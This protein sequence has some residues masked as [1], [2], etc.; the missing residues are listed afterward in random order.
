MYI[1]HNISFVFQNLPNT[2]VGI[3]RAK[4]TYGSAQCSKDKI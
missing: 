2:I 4:K 1:I 3:Q